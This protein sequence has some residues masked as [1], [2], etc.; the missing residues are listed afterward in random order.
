MEKIANFNFKCDLSPVVLWQYQNAPR[1]KGMVA[2]QQAFMDTAV[3]EFCEIIHRDFLN[4][5]TCNTDGL[6]MWGN[7]LQ[8]PRP[9]YQNAEG[10]TVQFSDAQYRLLLRARVYL[11]TFDGSARALNEFFHI[12]FPNMQV[13]VV[14]NY[15]MTA[16]INILNEVDPEIA[17]LFQPPFVD[18][19]LP[20]PAGVSYDTNAGG[21]VDYSKTFGFEG[22]TETSGFDQG[23]FYQG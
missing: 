18:T 10:E 20:R 8:V 4:L 14:D 6:S 1:L 16:T 5:A 11:L 13:E 3:T 7:V 15:D 9:V 2:N 23:T 19:F 17:V 21:D 12:L 22:M